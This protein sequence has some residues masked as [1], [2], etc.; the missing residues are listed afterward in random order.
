MSFDVRKA[1]LEIV[2]A[3]TLALGRLRDGW[4]ASRESRRARGLTSS[5]HDTASHAV[6][7]TRSLYGG[8][9]ASPTS[10][11]LVAI[12][13][14]SGKLRRA[15]GVK[16]TRRGGAARRPGYPNVATGSLLIDDSSSR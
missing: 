9:V 10:S 16:T 4:S 11:A 14:S 12:A 6:C 8:G 7:T 5:N 2:F 13:H 3:Q 1:L 15:A